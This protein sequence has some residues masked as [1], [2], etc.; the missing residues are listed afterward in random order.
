MNEAPMNQE[1]G[2]KQSTVGR[3]DLASLSLSLAAV[4]MASC[5]PVQPFKL[6]TASPFPSQTGAVCTT[7]IMAP[8][9]GLGP[10][11][12]VGAHVL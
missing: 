1:V 9:R 5:V 7:S 8:R 4:P 6:R 11:C 10:C 3:M 12:L 2:R